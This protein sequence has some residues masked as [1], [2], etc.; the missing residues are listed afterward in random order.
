MR[1]GR[2]ADVPGDDDA[3]AYMRRLAEVFV[4]STAAEGTVFGWGSASA[5]RLDEMCEQYLAGEPAEEGR[6]YFSIVMGAYLGELVVR[7][8]GGRWIW[9]PVART[10]AVEIA[11]G[12]RCFPHHKVAKR[13]A[14]GGEHSLRDFFDFMMTC[15]VPPDAKLTPREWDAIPAVGQTAKAIPLLEQA[16]ADSERVL[17]P[18]HPNTTVARGNLAAVVGKRRR[19]SGQ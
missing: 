4:Q 8:G 12:R 3:A 18:D 17:G 15:R 6:H 13:L 2:R 19:S 1:A 11:D 14:F 10:P 16:L 5:A 9:H 7:N